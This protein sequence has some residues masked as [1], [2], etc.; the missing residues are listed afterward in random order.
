MPYETVECSH[1]AAHLRTRPN[2]CK[3]VCVHVAVKFNVVP[4]KQ[5]H[6]ILFPKYYLQNIN[7]CKFRF[8]PNNLKNA[9]LFLSKNM[10][11]SI[12]QKKLVVFNNISFYSVNTNTVFKQFRWNLAQSSIFVFCHLSG[13]GY[14]HRPMP[15]QPKPKPRQRPISMK[16]S[17]V[18]PTSSQRSIAPPYAT[19]SAPR[20]P[21]KTSSSPR[22][23]SR[24]CSWRAA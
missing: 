22:S 14:A 17:P 10:H 13:L 19:P 4:C 23:G 21:R 8:C 16:H 11:V 20:R 3:L 9:M 7:P 12:I 2:P 15:K 5:I 1:F 18:N 24:R 6:D